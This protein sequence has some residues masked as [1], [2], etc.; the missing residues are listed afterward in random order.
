MRHPASMEMGSV[1]LDF[2]ADLR[3]I[4]SGKTA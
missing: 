1:F 2:I 4:F 3:R